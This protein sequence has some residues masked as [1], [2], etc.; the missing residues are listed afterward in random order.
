[1]DF[2]L[3][4]PRLLFRSFRVRFEE[5][6]EVDFLKDFDEQVE[7]HTGVSNLHRLETAIIKTKKVALIGFTGKITY[8][9]DKQAPPDL[10]YQMN[11]LADYAFFC[12]AGRKTTA[13]MGQTVRG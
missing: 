9:I 8:L 6:Y 11:L 13:G 4:D 2:L 3:P 10:V 12:G 5:F 7:F 1:M